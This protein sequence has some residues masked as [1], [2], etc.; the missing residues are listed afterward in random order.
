MRKDQA[1]IALFTL[2]LLS[3]AFLAGLFVGRDTTVVSFK[4]LPESTVIH[5]EV[6][7]SPV[8]ER[9]IE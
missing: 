7:K 5:F 6:E 1:L 2:F 3:L 8:N 9:R 4:G